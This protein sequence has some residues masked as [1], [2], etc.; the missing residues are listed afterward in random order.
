MR[1]GASGFLLKSEP[2]TVVR[3]TLL[4]IKDFGF[5]K[6]IANLNLLSEV[7]YNACNTSRP[8]GLH[9][10]VIMLLVALN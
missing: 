9:L 1:M 4:T 8:A 10:T 7:S 5:V 6:D 2:F 3:D